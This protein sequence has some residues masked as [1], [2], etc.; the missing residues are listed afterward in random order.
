MS[1]LITKE[2]AMWALESAFCKNGIVNRHGRIKKVYWETAFRIIGNII[3]QDT[4]IEWVSQGNWDP[5]PKES[6][7]EDWR[8]WTAAAIA[9]R[10]KNLSKVAEQI[11]SMEQHHSSSFVQAYLKAEFDV[12]IFQHN[13]VERNL[14]GV[15]YTQNPMITLLFLQRAKDVKFPNSR[16]I[17][18][19]LDR[20][21][22]DL[23]TT[24]CPKDKLTRCHILRMIADEEHAH[25]PKVAIRYKHQLNI[26]NLK[27]K[28]NYGKVEHIEYEED[29]DSG[30]SEPDYSPPNTFGRYRHIPLPPSY[31]DPQ[32]DLTECGDVESHPGPARSWTGNDDLINEDDGNTSD[33]DLELISD[34]HWRDMG[35]AEDM[36]PGST[37]SPSEW[38]ENDSSP[39]PSPPPY[40]SNEDF[41]VERE[42]H[43]EL[44][45]DV[46]QNSLRILNMMD[47]QRGKEEALMEELCTLEEV[48]DNLVKK[49]EAREKED[50]EF[51]DLAIILLKGANV[52]LFIILAALLAH[53][54]RPV[55]GSQENQMYYT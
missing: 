34:P 37:W 9:P 19:N 25:R 36:G 41:P 33:I 42:E 6:N 20:K 43:D 15:Q 17:Y 10:R 44:S 29:T 51:R 54:T 26:T 22:T 49:E 46:Q 47:E 31:N 23:F 32:Q 30:N 1:A 45:K 8:D 12:N 55:R 52:I 24:G 40:L 21:I 27:N 39:A 35:P 28:Q 2:E 11:F 13:Y 50:A 3:P 4:W 18:E 48:T 53:F 38:H 7:I 5:E 14:Q 16:R